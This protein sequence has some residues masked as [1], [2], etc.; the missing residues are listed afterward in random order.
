MHDPRLIVLDGLPGSGKTTTGQW[1]TSELQNYGIDSHW[2]PETEISHPL[3]WYEHWNGT[4]YQTPDFARTSVE[5]FL[6]TSLSRWRDFTAL[7]NGTR[8]QYVAESVFFQNAVAMFLMGGAGPAVLTEYALDVQKS[9]M[10]LIQ[11]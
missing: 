1:L 9:Y 10:R 4:E 5:I 7:A 2:L 3:W 6:Q 8:Q 11:P